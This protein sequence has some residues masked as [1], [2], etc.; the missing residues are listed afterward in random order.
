MFLWCLGSPLFQA[1]E[2]LLRRWDH[3]AENRR[4]RVESEVGQALDE[5][6][7][8]DEDCVVFCSEKLGWPWMALIEFDLVDSLWP[9]KISW[10]LWGLSS[11]SAWLL[12]SWERERDEVWY[13]WSND[14][15]INSNDLSKT[16]LEIKVN[17]WVLQSRLAWL[18]LVMVAVSCSFPQYIAEKQDSLVFSGIFSEYGRFLLDF[19]NINQFPGGN[20][21]I[22]SDT[23]P[24][25]QHAGAGGSFR[26]SLAFLQLCALKTLKAMFNS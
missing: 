18:R 15:W 25:K 1:M 19:T 24:W 9:W 26:F 2:T 11:P 20:W 12:I 23:K 4:Q 5:A 13:R 22:G 8:V 6:G 14:I 7:P 16:S 3:C 17:V 21:I 10:N